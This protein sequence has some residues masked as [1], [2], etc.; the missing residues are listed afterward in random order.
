MK[1]PVLAAYRAW[2]MAFTACTVALITVVPVTLLDRGM[3]DPSVVLPA[4]GVLLAW[5]GTFVGTW[6]KG[7]RLRHLD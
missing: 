1:I 2:L 5:W 4:V 7:A 3:H 6:V